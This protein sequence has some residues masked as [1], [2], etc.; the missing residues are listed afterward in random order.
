MS[1][2]NALLAALLVASASAF[3]PS[4]NA[5][6]QIALSATHATHAPYFLDVVEEPRPQPIIKKTP[7]K[8][9]ANRHK[10]GLFSPVVYVAKE[11]LGETELNR[12]RGNVISMHSDVIKNFVS[13]AETGFGNQ[14][15]RALYTKTDV[16][17]NGKIEMNELEKAL[18]T[19]GF[20][21]LQEKQIKGIF[22]R[23]GG[24]EKGY[25]TL[26]EW[27]AEAP[28]TLK[29]N[30]VKLAKSNGGELGFLV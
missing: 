3:A 8:T 23:A 20:T 6:R 11:V 5:Q 19:L 29:T 12:L 16:D 4:P 13:T 18:K 21:W 30:L 17:G 27:M 28:K 15:L 22:K 26:E 25:L 10:E 1:R 7:V 2:Y 9:T 14:V 24:E